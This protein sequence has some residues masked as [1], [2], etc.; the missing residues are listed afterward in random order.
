M[1]IDRCQTIDAGGAIILGPLARI[2]RDLAEREPIVRF[3]FFGNYRR[4]CDLTQ[5][6]V[7]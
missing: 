3:T 6:K 5:E 1:I 2:N 7:A 4:L